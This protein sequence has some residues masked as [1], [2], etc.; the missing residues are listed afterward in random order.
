[1]ITH[2]IFA[3]YKTRSSI[4][5]GLF[6]LFLIASPLSA[7][8][9]FTCENQFFLTLSTEPPSL[10]EVIIDPQTGAAV[11]Q[12]ING[13]I[14]IAVNAAGYRSVDNFIY[15]ID[16]D[17]RTLVRLDAFGNAVVLA[18]L[19]LKPNLAYF[20]GDI[21]PDG[22]YLV[23]VGT[24]SFANGS[25]VAADIARVDLEDPGYAVTSLTINV[26]A[27]IFDVAF[28][29]VTGVLYGYDSSTQRLIR[30]DPFTG[31]ITFPFPSTTAP[32]ITGSLFFDAYANLFAYG[33]PNGFSDQNSLYQINPL[34]GSSTFLTQGAAA[35][36]SDGCSCPYTIELGKSVLP[37]EALPCSEVVYTFELVNSS[38]ILQQGLRLEDRLPPGF[39]FVGI[40][41]N[42]LGG[43]LLS[44]PGDV[45][46]NLQNI[47][48]PTGTHEIKII[49]NTGDV[50]A[51]IYKNQAT[52]FNLPAS[53]GLK[54]IS[55]NRMTLVKDD[56]TVLEI[57]RF[58][59]DSILL[60]QALC[61]GADFL[62]LNA[63]QYG[64]VLGGV[65]TFHWED[66]STLPYL[67]ITMPGQYNA[68][69]KAG[70][71][72]ALVSFTVVESDINVGVIQD[73]FTI[74]L[75][76]SLVLEAFSTNTG[77]QTIYQW[78][79]PQPGSIRC[80]DCESSVARPFNDILYTITATNE[81][82][83]S[84]TEQVRVK[85]E[86]NLKVYF[87]NVFKPN[88]SEDGLNGYFYASGD[89]YTV[90]ESLQ[91]FSR[92]GEKVF[93]SRYIPLNDPNSG[94]D[95]TFKGEPM[96][97]GVYVWVAEVIF[98]DGQSFT[99]SG[100]VTIVR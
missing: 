19:A 5:G 2:P 64:N 88:I 40:Q 73:N 21:T 43:T 81:L 55:D 9:P 87:P 54:R 39:T 60:D 65:V 52:L 17:N 51:G 7:Q 56:S 100:D 94:W 37:L 15:S 35:Q 45:V 33:S 44:Q 75:G 71:D 85:V 24:L 27:Q 79:D 41:S 6:L 92:W 82:G 66:G 49:V 32:V 13:N 26:F 98:L 4:F 95:G 8:K 84:D 97:P 12:S 38:R 53:L 25:S 29:P 70:C 58:P 59:F 14:N 23:L 67:D 47:S 34:T 3:T 28:H 1:M 80:L 74:Q 36:S 77:L 68:I 90:L 62:R 76:D 48:L 30:I 63:Q 61:S 86:K 78:Q 99:A 18:N 91:V 57:I 50:P 46:F 31:D 72:S 69:L 42:P 16:P 11:F 93:E 20:A 22:R 10:N 83:C 96:L 89:Q